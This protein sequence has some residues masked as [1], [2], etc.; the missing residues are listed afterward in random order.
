LSAFASVEMSSSISSALDLCAMIA[1]KIFKSGVTVQN[2]LVIVEHH[3]RCR[4]IF[5]QVPENIWPAFHFLFALFP[6][7]ESLFLI[8][9][10]D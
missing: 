3:N 5:D 6:F 8:R 2:I 4:A 7:L 10:Y 1:K 9:L